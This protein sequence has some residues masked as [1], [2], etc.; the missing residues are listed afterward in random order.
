MLSNFIQN[1]LPFDVNF[2]PKNTY[3]VGGF[4][5]DCLLN[6][7]RKYLDLDFILVENTLKIA[8]QIANKYQAG[9]VVLDQKRQIARIVFPNM[10]IDF[11]QQEGNTLIDDLKR[12]DYTINA[13][14]YNIFSEEL[15]DPFNGREDLIKKEIKM[16]SEA[17]LKDDPLRLLRA[18]R[19]AS[20]LNFTIDQNTCFTIKKLAPFLTQIAVERI[21]TE[22]SYLL[23]TNN[24]SF[25]L[26]QC[27]QDSLLSIIFQNITVEKIENLFLIDKI[28]KQLTQ[29]YSQIN[30]GIN[31]NLYLL[32][33][34]NL[35]SDKIEIAYQ[36]LIKLKY[37]RLEIRQIITIIKYS[38][39]LLQKDK[40]DTLRE[41]YFFFLDIGNLFVLIVILAL[42][43]NADQQL[44]NNLINQ[45]LD[46]N[47]KVAHP[48]SLLTG[49]DLINH[50][51]LSPS[52]QIGKLLIE[53]QIAYIEG[54]IIDFN[55]ALNYAQFLLEKEI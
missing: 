4:V 45:Y 31:A 22:L 43:L 11:A 5:R 12:R 1:C 16:I 23:V 34:A 17:N 24:S 40:F 2:L 25:W 38:Q 42:S 35:L 49:N 3:L 27:Y 33:L 39:N 9:F 36:E 44:I 30:E 41:Q 19:Q 7:E 18:Y 50:L 29:K 37:S 52:P 6:R 10:T 55:Q 28:T 53:I 46:I 48:V 15:I 47:N 54:K 8:K 21:T 13:I 14:A 32:K 51:K 26:K 20:Q